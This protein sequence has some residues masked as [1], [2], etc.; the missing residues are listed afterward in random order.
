MRYLACMSLLF[1][2][3]ASAL[4]PGAG[5]TEWKSIDTDLEKD[6]VVISASTEQAPIDFYES[7]CKSFGGY[8]LF[9]SGGDIRYA[10]VLKYLAHPIKIQHPYSFHDLATNKIEWIYQVKLNEEGM[11]KLQW[12]GL[13]YSLSVADPESGE[14]HLQVYAVRLDGHR[15]CLA[16]ITNTQEKARELVYN[17][18]A[19]CR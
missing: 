11:G 4:V 15:S 5:R 3:S 6:C 12:K 19:G 17:S 10:P 2:G 16:G 8:Q 7:E 9:I 14:N 18:T 1:I 13:V